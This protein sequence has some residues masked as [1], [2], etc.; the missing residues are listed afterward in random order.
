MHGCF[1]GGREPVETSVSLLSESE[2]V[3]MQD[4]E[5]EVAIPEVERD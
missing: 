3:R 4:M 1:A 5:D 2:S